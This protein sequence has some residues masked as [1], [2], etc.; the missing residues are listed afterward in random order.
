M[1]VDGQRLD[2]AKMAAR[3]YS[4]SVNDLYIIT[5]IPIGAVGGHFKVGVTCVIFVDLQKQI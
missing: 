4:M 5:E 3:R 2:V 1:G